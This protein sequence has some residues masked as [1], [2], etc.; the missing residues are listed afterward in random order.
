MTALGLT[1]SNI[2]A[3][4]KDKFSLKDD[5]GVV[6]LDVASG[7]P[8]AQKGLEPGD[9]ILE[10]S[11]Q[12]IKNAG[13]DRREDRRSQAGRPQL[14]PGAGRSP[15]RAALFRA[16]PR[17]GL[18]PGLI[19]GGR[20]ERVMSL[21]R[22][23]FPLPGSPGCR[24]APSDRRA[25]CASARAAATAGLAWNAMP[26]PAA[27]SIGRSLAP[28]PTASVA[29]SG[30][31]SPPR[32][33]RARPAWRRRSTIGVRTVPAIRPSAISRR[34]ATTRSKPREAAIGSAKTVK[35]PE[36]S[37]VRTP[38]A[39]DVAT[40]ARAP[41]ITRMRSRRFVEHRDR[42]TP[43]QRDPFG[44]GGG[45]IEFA[46]HRAP[47]D[48]GDLRAHADEIGQLVEHLVLDDR[49][50]EI[51]DEQPLAAPLRRLH[52]NVDRGIADRVA[53]GAFGRIGRDAAEREVAR[54]SRREP[55]GFA[56]DFQGAGDRG[57][58]VGQHTSSGLAD[59]GPADQRHDPGHAVPPPRF[60]FAMRSSQNARSSQKDG[61]RL[62]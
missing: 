47:R 29:A 32:A 48:L 41:G 20:R 59:P 4:L 9:V 28:S 23:R 51:G 40:S 31:P 34:F 54:H 46:V 61:A 1:L 57:G 43:Q 25:R 42:Q 8:A 21:S 60:G 18:I 14:D 15:G 56:A 37:A 52:D 7:S 50:F 12:E 26:S 19:A 30:T 10:A 17:S 22:E 39:R 55:I 11:Q 3:E 44:E 2:T 53:R 6:V 45:E 58:D 16:A 35:P 13:P 27:S 5:K 49:Q 36:T 33:R 38:A 62:G 24:A